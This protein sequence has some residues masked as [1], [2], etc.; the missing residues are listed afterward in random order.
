MPVLQKNNMMNK[1]YLIPV[2]I[3]AL[4]IVTIVLIT[5]NPPTSTRGKPM[6]VAAMTV[7]TQIVKSQDYQVQVGSF[8]VVKPRTQSSLVT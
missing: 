5:A 6:P 3:I 8:G 2:G 7:E 1:K 4:A